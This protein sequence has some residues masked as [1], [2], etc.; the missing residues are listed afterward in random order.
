MK[1]HWCNTQSRGDNR[2]TNPASHSSVLPSQTILIEYMGRT[3]FLGWCS[4]NPSACA[5][6]E[7]VWLLD[8]HLYKSCLRIECLVVGPSD[9]HFCVSY[10]RSAV[11]V[12]V[13]DYCKVPVASCSVVRSLF[14]DYGTSSEMSQIVDIG[15]RVVWHFP[16]FSSTWVSNRPMPRPEL[17]R[18]HMPAA[19]RNAFFTPSC[20]DRLCSPPSLL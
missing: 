6:V 8:L 17:S 2:R 13:R 4:V 20:Y 15:N 14:E 5:T 18:A 9:Q 7:Y 12:L 11:W 19:A 1:K 16:T 10:V 3:A